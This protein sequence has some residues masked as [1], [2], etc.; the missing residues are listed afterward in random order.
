M[1]DP[2]GLDAAIT[3]IQ[4]AEQQ[5]QAQSAAQAEAASRVAASL[6]QPH[7]LLRDFAA[8]AAAL[9]IPTLELTEEELEPLP[10]WRW[11]SQTNAHGGWLRVK[12]VVR[13]RS[14]GIRGWRV[15]GSGVITTHGHLVYQSMV[16]LTEVGVAARHPESGSAVTQ[17]RGPW[18]KSP[19]PS[20]VDVDGWDNYR[21]LEDLL[22][23]FLLRQSGQ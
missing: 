15:F 6:E 18:E 20:Q 13:S 4:A 9:Q 17:Y 5:R 12:F 1:D 3:R 21:P 2:G 23:E 7:P 8:R 22:A 10:R 14:S 16:N 19:V 11:R